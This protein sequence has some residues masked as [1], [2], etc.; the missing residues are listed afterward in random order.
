MKYPFVL[1]AALLWTLPL[2]SQGEKKASNLMESGDYASAAVLYQNLSEKSPSNPKLNLNLAECY[3]HLPNKTRYAEEPLQRI[4]KLLES[5]PKNPYFIKAKQK[6]GVLYRLEHKFDKSLQTLLEVQQ[7]KPTPE[8]SKELRITKNAQSAYAVK[9]EHILQSPGEAIN[10]VEDQ[11][12]PFLSEKT[13]VFIY[14]S[15][16]KTS[17]AKEKS[18][19]GQFDENIFF[20]MLENENDREPD[21]YSEPLNSKES[22]SNGQIAED[23]TFIFICRDDDI[24]EVHK[25]GSKWGKPKKIKAINSKSKDCYPV[26]SPDGNTLYFA[27]NRAGGKG[28]MDIY[29]AQKKSNDS[30]GAP[31]LVSGINT[32]E[33]EIS[34][35]LHP[36]GNF[37]FVSKGHNSIGGFDIFTAKQTA[38]GNFSEVTNIGMPI[39]DVRDDLSFFM[40]RDEKRAFVASERPGGRGG[41]DIYMIDFPEE[42]PEESI[43]IAEPQVEAP[44]V[45]EEAPPVKEPA[46]E[47]PEE[48]P[49]VVAQE[50]PP[51]EEQQV[52]AAPSG[53][54]SQYTVQVGAF[55]KELPTS[56]GFFSSL[57]GEVILRK[58]KDFNHY[59]YGQYD[60]RSEARAAQ[61]KVRRMGYPH[62]FVRKIGWYSEN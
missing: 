57:N 46:P 37:Y 10:T 52:V 28:G 62:A 40:T 8:T 47:V 50:T 27:S 3:M 55:Q 16:E 49:V 31:Q 41:L 44:V 14:T 6:L 22:E 17:F 12:A 11:Y 56:H 34:P 15:K 32:E 43:A 7:I 60:S 21:P 18:S 20:I 35:F 19:D 4:I 36:N 23:G 38:P 1:I 29:F 33:D 9:K 45:A 59:T 24:Y 54:A 53:D 25:E 13:G 5:K 26:L 30:W 58:S 39:N 48:V 61:N 42:Q 51:V 2:M